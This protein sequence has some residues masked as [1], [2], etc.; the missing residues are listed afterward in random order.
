MKEV[1]QKELEQLDFITPYLAMLEVAKIPMEERTAFMAKKY[2][3]AMNLLHNLLSTQFGKVLVGENAVRMGMDTEILALYNKNRTLATDEKDRIMKGLENPENTQAKGCDYD[4]DRE[5]A[6][7]LY[8]KLW[9][10]NTNNPLNPK[11]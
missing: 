7:K 1:E 3:D 6:E 8:L 9:S 10:W 4:L 5:Q 11:E 2:N